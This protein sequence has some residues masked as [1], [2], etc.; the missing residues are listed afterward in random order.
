MRKSK[1]IN[2][3]INKFNKG[4]SNDSKLSSLEEEN[5][6]RKEEKKNKK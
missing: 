2:E 6:K 5:R 1:K 4:Y 3:K